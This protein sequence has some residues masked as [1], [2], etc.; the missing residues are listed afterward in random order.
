MGILHECHGMSIEEA[1]MEGPKRTIDQITVWL[2]EQKAL[3]KKYGHLTLGQTMQR[4]DLADALA[5][6][7][8]KVVLAI[9]EAQIVWILDA[10]KK[11]KAA[12][13]AYK[14]EEK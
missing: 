5:E 12:L 9:D 6:A 13:A 3:C 14:G 4:L 2:E 10:G 8:E 1:I 7:A 11:L